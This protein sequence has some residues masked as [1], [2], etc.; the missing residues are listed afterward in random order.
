MTRGKTLTIFWSSSGKLVLCVDWNAESS[1]PH[2]EDLECV[3]IENPT[4]NLC[5]RRL[6]SVRESSI[7]Y[8]WFEPMVDCQCLSLNRFE[9]NISGDFLEL[10]IRQSRSKL[11]R[12]ILAILENQAAQVH[13]CL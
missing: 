11:H 13:T 12:N 5:V 6:R 10:S 4:G 8:R 7:E 9:Y 2:V 1:K 3:A